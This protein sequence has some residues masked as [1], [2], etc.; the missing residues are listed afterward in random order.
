MTKNVFLTTIDETKDRLDMLYFANGKEGEVFSCT[1]GIS[2]AEAGIKYILS[3]NPID[4]II[5]I[6][7]PVLA[8]KNELAERVIADVPIEHIAN[9]DTMSSYGFLCYRLKEY[10]DQ[11]D[12]EILDISDALTEEEQQQCRDELKA[13]KDTDYPDIPEREMFARLSGD[14]QLARRFEKKVL[15][16]KSP[17]EKKWIRHELFTRMDS[18]HKIHML[19]ENSRT[20]IRFMPVE[21]DGVI[22]IGDMT[23]IVQETLGTEEEG[24]NLF[25]DIQ[26]MNAV[27]GNT[28][29]STFL[30]LNKRIGYN[31]RLNELIKSE[32][33]PDSFCGRVW[34]V[35]ESYE[36]QK[37]I[38]GIEIFLDY[39]KDK[40]L[41]E[42]W[43]TL[44]VKDAGADMLF[45]GMDMV[46]EGITLC[47]I[48]LISCG[49]DV[50]RKMVRSYPA[51]GSEPSIYLDIIVRA[52]KEDY[53]KMLQGK[54]LSIPELLKWSLRKGFYQ[55]TLTIIESKVPED[56]IRRGIYYYAENQ[57]DVKNMM[58]CMN[59]YYWNTPARMRWAYNDI[60][61]EFIKFFGRSEIDY[62]QKP[63]AVAK[64][65]AQ[66][67]I[68]LLK[69]PSGPL[70]R[71]FSQLHDR[72]LL[73]EL[74][75]C[76]YQIGNL[77]NQVNHAH[78]DRAAV[79]A[80]GPIERK[81][82]R[83]DLDRELGRFIK[84]YDTACE[85]THKKRESVILESR[86]FK[87]Y[88]RHNEIQPLETEHDFML[89]NSY[90]CNW[91]GKD[92][93]IRINMLKPETDDWDEDEE[94][95]GEGG[96]RAGGKM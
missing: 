24:L 50:I 36:I 13:F 56:M 44:G 52:I 78:I 20:T 14:R 60:D 43:Q 73:F 63:D 81:D 49:I 93:L 45:A 64:D 70:P 38:S 65:Y 9:L 75:L 96:S 22:G 51:E 15:W 94:D 27:D 6:G 88:A 26:G 7:N 61:H 46:D 32:H 19:P 34:N 17:A 23:D 80:D 68:D 79:V 67:R 53:G 12:F 2:V 3:K 37:L 72:D 91:D 8:E 92:V 77:R 83:E 89:E 25:M 82:M 30:L 62:R 47:N 18:F 84:L 48:D 21:M 57:E 87:G 28:L 10:I 69:G 76:Y 71:A 16:G 39:G 59:V 58:Q 41:K 42:Y 31:C 33:E 54:R 29:I 86:R 55:Q 1:T 40:Q 4:E 85:K 11:M 5:V 74:L 90:V 66:L 95:G 35:R